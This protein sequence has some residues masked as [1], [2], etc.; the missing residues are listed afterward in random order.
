MNTNDINN[1]IG[2]L[3]CFMGTYAKD[4]LP[5]KTFIKRPLGFIIN[6]DPSY[7]SGEHWVALFITDMNKA[8]YFD[9]FGQDP[10]CCEILELLKFNNIS[11]IIYNHKR[12][13][14][15]FSISCG[16]FCILYL[17]M[18]CN[19]YSFHEFLK[20]FSSNTLNNEILIRNI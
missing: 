13:Q 14:S 2:D 12:I 16:A 6:T 19:K 18:R 17:K 5:I 3:D 11:E 1:V 9:S 10:I 8:E 15:I 7:K 4:Q 20:L